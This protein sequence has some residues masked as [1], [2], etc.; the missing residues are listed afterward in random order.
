[1]E[2]HFEPSRDGVAHGARDDNPSRGCLGLKARGDIYIVA[3]DVIAFGDDIAKVKADPE[4]Y[5]L[6]LALVAIC[7]G[8]SLLELDRGLE[9]VYGAAELEQAAIACQP[10]HP[11]AT[12]CGSRREPSVHM[13]Q[14][15]R[16][17][18]AF[19]LAHEPGRSNNIGK[20]DRC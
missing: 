1:V 7:L 19:I 13:L 2:G 14:K 15:P 17:G 5:S 8:H 6:V 16:N 12:A 18:A 9:G 4:H 20:K 10:D 3:I 11:P